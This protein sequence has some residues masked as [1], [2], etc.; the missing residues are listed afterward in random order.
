MMFL[1]AAAA[2]STNAHAQARQGFG[3]G[4]VAG[5]PS[6]LTVAWAASEQRAFQSHLSWSVVNDRMRVSADYLQTVAVLD[7]SGPRLPV[8]VGLGG[9]VSVGEPAWLGARIPLG[10][11]LIPRQVPIEPFLELAPTVYVFPDTD[12]DLEGALGA[13]IYF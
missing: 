10:V 6:G 12:V 2:L 13:R 5:E 7:T 3:L 9:V 1:L 4:L 8:Y 11:A